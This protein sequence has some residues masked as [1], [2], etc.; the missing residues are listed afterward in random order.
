VL[1]VAKVTQASAAGY[2]DYLEGK[3]KAPELGDYYLRDGE[4]VE[5]PGRWAAGAGAVGADPELPVTGGQLRSLMAVRRPDTGEPMRRAGGSGE[6]VAALDATFSAPKSVSAVWALADPDLRARVEAAH[7]AA[8]DRALAY[9]VRH[10]AMIR[11]RIDQ[12]T[13]VHVKATRLVATSWRHTTSR[14]VAGQAPDPQLHSHVLLH[15]AVR[16][17]GQTMAIDS[18]TWLLHRREIGAAY[19]T[20]LAREMRLLGF[21]IVRGAGRAGRYFEIDGIPGELLE[22]WS[23]R[24]AEIH[25][26]IEQ[27]LADQKRVLAVEVAA[28][29]PEADVARDRLA[30]LEEYGQLSPRQERAIATATRTAKPLLTRRD[31]DQEWT[32]TAHAYGV[33]RRELDGLRAERPALLPASERELLD[34]LTEFDAT[35]PSRDARAVALERSAGIP[36][37]DALTTLIAMRESGSLLRLADGTV[38]TREHRARER[39]TAVVAERLAASPPTSPI[40][41]DVAAKEAARLDRELG[42]R[43]SDEQRQALMLACGEKRLVVIEGQAGTG[44]STTLTGIARAHQAAGQQIIIA[45]TAALA[46][47]R[48]AGELRTAGVYCSAYSTV[49]LYAAIEKGHV[50]LGPTTTV[51]HDEAALAST[52]EQQQLLHAVEDAGA[53][54]IEVGDPRQNPAVGAGGLWPRLEQAA[55]AHGAHV[56]LTRNQRAHD[57]ADR[58][59]QKW[60]RDGEHEKALRGYAARDRLH[61]HPDQR[62]A[63]DAALDAAHHDQQQGLRTIVIAQSSNEHLDVLNARAQAIRDQHHELGPDPVPIPGRPYALHPGDAIQIRRTIPRPGQP[64]RNGTGATIIATSPSDPERTL[65]LELA[66]GTHV[67]LTRAQADSGDLRLAYVQH[68]FPAQGHTTDTTH[69]IVADHPTR[70]G[71]YVALTRARAA[72]H[73]HTAE[74]TPPSDAGPSR[75]RL[76]MLAEQLART[77]PDLPSID[78]P[79][80]HETTI[81]QAPDEQHEP[82]LIAEPATRD[83]ELTVDPDPAAASQPIARDANPA[84]ER[85]WPR[86]DGPADTMQ[87]DRDQVDREHQP[88]WEP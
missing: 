59:D 9:A 65:E 75:D 34:A 17:D 41:A 53:R 25:A 72:S 61:F 54:L 10:A 28:G 35:F 86:R 23:S 82:T 87:P 60:F 66:D 7:E 11:Q 6:A 58:R 70:E 56:E 77:E 48:L 24:R 8:I 80:N 88:E 73:I 50:E 52:R 33:S 67:P 78:Q 64:L 36:I 55:S 32:R 26:A 19:R 5:A 16:R 18:R 40:P 37:D 51:I 84:R 62:R 31:L 43:L 42:G 63:E 68:P 13:V 44:K 45:S 74:P 27:H 81:T 4:R 14:A 38:T 46:A 76:A 12:R 1:T 21:Q 29:G 85:T 3:A 20:E 69:L 47:E 39:H 30:L 15:A 79:L 83:H 71:T 2:A 22:R 57:P 49:A